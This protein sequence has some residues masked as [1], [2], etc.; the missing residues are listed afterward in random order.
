MNVGEVQTSGI[1]WNSRF[2]HHIGEYK[3]WVEDEFNTILD[4]KSSYVS[5]APLLERVGGYSQ[6]KWRN[7]IKFGVEK[8]DWSTQLT[9][10]TYDKV[11][12]ISS[13]AN[14]Q[15]GEPS[16]GYMPTHTI[17]DLN[18]GYKGIK[19]LQLNLTVLNVFNVQPR[20]STGYGGFYDNVTGPSVYLAGR[21]TYK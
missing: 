3:L 8:G 21:Y 1:D 5:G 6:E 2:E 18:I 11:L 4:Y 15:A 20:F 13:P 7:N 17:Y 16:P 14:L 9:A 10:V 19:N 12:N